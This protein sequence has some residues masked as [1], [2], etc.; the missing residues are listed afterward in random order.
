[1]TPSCSSPLA[2]SARQVARTRRL[3]SRVSILGACPESGCTHTYIHTSRFHDTDIDL[4]SQR[5]KAHPCPTRAITRWLDC[6]DAHP[7]PRWE[8][9]RRLLRL[10]RIL[11]SA[12]NPDSRPSGTGFGNVSSAG[13]ASGPAWR[14]LQKMLEAQDDLSGASIGYHSRGT[15]HADLEIR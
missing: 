10:D 8:T 5:E 2:P 13:C 6:V 7:R 14:L 3:G 11:A 4:A 9:S 1:M 15:E 12:D